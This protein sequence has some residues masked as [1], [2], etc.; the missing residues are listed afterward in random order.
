MPVEEF[1]AGFRPRWRR[2]AGQARSFSTELLLDMPLK[3]VLCRFNQRPGLAQTF[4]QDFDGK[5]EQGG[6]FSYRDSSGETRAGA[7]TNI[8]IPKRIELATDEYGLI[9]IRFTD[10]GASSKTSIQFKKFTE[11]EALWLA[12]IDALL[13]RISS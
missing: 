1:W 12:S 10:L 11:D 7:F 3:E 2:P 13:V 4:G 8:R 9:S 6:Q 5:I